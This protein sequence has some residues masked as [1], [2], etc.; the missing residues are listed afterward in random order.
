MKIIGVETL[1]GDG[2]LRV[3][4]FVKVTTDEGL[5]GWAEYYDAFA[6]APLAPIIEAIARKAIGMDPRA[7]GLLS[8]SLLATSRLSSGGLAHQAVGAIE[9]ACLDIAGKAAGLP[10]YALFGGPFRSRVPLYWTHCG[11]Y[12]VRHADFFENELGYEPVRSLDDFTRLGREA[13]AA[14]F[15]AIKTNPVFFDQ[16]RPYMFNGGFT[17]RPGFLDRSYSDT[18]IAAI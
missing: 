15:R 3:C 13:V 16:P 4:S 17:I 6:A 1:H 12:Q 9:N 10:V 18:Q 7:F 8:E 2:G 5:V 14:G 11:S